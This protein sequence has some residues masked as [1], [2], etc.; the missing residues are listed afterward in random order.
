[1][2]PVIQLAD[3]GGP[4]FVSCMLIGW[5]VTTQVGDNFIE[6]LLNEVGL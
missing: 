6:A 5:I 1:M 2:E 3:E 4:V